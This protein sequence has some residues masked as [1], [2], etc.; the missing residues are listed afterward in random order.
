MARLERVRVALERPPA[1]LVL[2]EQVAPRHQEPVLVAPEPAGE[3]AGE[4][5]AADQDEQ[6]VRPQDA[7]AAVA[8]A[9]D[10]LLEALGA[11]GA[12]DLRAEPDVDRVRRLD[13]F[14]EVPGHAPLERRAADEQRDA[15][16]EL[17]EV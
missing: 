10:E 5:V 16:G 9:E 8:L 13:S 11:V 14:D 4:R 2:E 12:H 6:R 17:R 7:V 1:P 3:R 15:A